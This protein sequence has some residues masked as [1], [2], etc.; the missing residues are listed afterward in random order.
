MP[1]RSLRRL[2]L[3]KYDVDSDT[4]EN[5]ESIENYINDEVMGKTGWEFAEI[6]IN[7]AYTSGSP[8]KFKHNASFIP[9]DVLI[10]SV[11]KLVGESSVGTAAVLYDEMDKDFIY[12][13]CTSPGATVRFFFGTFKEQKR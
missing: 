11:K 1:Y 4:R 9:K 3:D 7:G 8:Y 10:T 6:E 12:F 5:F 13:T 2:K